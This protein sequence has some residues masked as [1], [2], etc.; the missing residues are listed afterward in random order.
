MSAWA[1]TG[2]TLVRV[3]NSSRYFRS[4]GLSSDRDNQHGIT[5]EEGVVVLVLIRYKTTSTWLP[6]SPPSIFT[7]SG[8]VVPLVETISK[9]DST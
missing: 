2:I 8:S 1:M 6:P 4:S 3:A 5:S 9:K 7:I